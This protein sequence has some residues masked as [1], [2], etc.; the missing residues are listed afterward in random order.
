MPTAYSVSVWI[1]L[2]AA[3][4]W[5][6]GMVF[7]VAVVLPILKDPEHRSVYPLLLR[8][9]GMRFRTIGW[10][11]LLALVATGFFQLWKL[12]FG[13]TAVVRGEPFRGT[14]GHLLAVKLALVAAILVL[15]VVHDFWVGPQAGRLS[16]SRPGSDAARRYRLAASWIGRLNLVLALLVT[17]LGVHLLRGRPL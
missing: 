15:S 1:H 7:L 10:I 6:G 3:V 8:R 9:A 14:F 13:P 17:L 4:V 5:I 2:M 16:R 11:C 12:G